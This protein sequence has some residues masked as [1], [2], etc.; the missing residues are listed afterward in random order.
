MI[1]PTKLRSLLSVSLVFSFAASFAVA[2]VGQDDWKLQ[3]LSYNNPGLEVDLGVGLWAWPMPMDYDGDGDIDLLVACPDKPSNGVYFFEN[4]SQDPA[5]QMPVFKP[6]V[7]VGKATS[8]MQVSYVDQ[9]P[10]ILRSGVEFLRDDSTGKFDFDHGKKIYPRSNVHSNGVRGN[11]WRYM[12][13]DGDGD[14]DIVVG[15]GDWTDYGWD[16][17]YDS[18]GRWRN[19]PLHGHVYLI[20][21]DGT[22]DKADYSETPQRLKAAG[23][24]IDVYGWPSPN[25][26][27][28]D[29][30]G[31]LDLLCGEFLDGFT[32]F[33]NVGSRTGPK[34]AAGQKLLN[35]SGDPLVMHLQMITPTALDWDGD[36]DL[37]LIVGDEDGRVAF[38]EN[39]GTLREGQPVFRSPRYFQQ[40][41]DT[42]KFGALATPFAY[43]WDGDGDEDILCGNTA[44]NI[45]LFENLGEAENGM[46]RWSAPE[47]LQVRSSD[48]HGAEDFRVLAGPSGSIQGP[49]EAKWGYTTLSVADWD[50]DGDPDI[51]Y[52]SILARLGLLRNE[53]GVLVESELTMTPSEQPPQ[54]YWWQT[55]ATNALTQWRTTPLATDFDGDGVLDL[56][57]LDQQGFLTLRRGAKQAERIFVDESGQPVQLNPKSC[58]GSGRVKLAVVDWDGDGRLDVLVNSENATWY[59]NGADRDGKVVLKK[60]GRLAERNVAGHTSSPAACD[61]NRDSKPDLLV[62][63]ENGRLYYIEHDD[64]RQFTAEEVAVSPTDD[65]SSARMP[66]LVAEEFIFTR[67]PTPEC[68]ASTICQTSRGLVSAWFAG[69]KEGK[70]DVGIWTSYHDGNGWSNP[71]QVAD[72]VQ[73]DGLRYPCWNPVL[74]QPPGD[75]PTLLFFKVGPNPREWWGEM[76]V[77]YDRGRTFR[78]RRRLP[79]GIDGPVRCKPILLDDG[80][81]LCGSSTEYDG[82][83]IHFERVELD[84]GV[85]TGTWQRIGP[86]NDASKFNAIQ[87]TLLRQDDGTLKALCRTKEGVIVSTQS[88]DGGRSWSPL[89]ATE[90]PNPNSG[91]DVVNLQDGRHL[92]I[93]NHLGSGQT[94]WGR[95]GQL[96]LAISDDG[97]TWQRVGVLEQEKGAEFSYP[98]IIQT[99]DG[100]VHATYTWKRKRVKHVVLNP[101]ALVHE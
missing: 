15:A 1:D 74:Y 47:L 44:G 59:R 63:A 71:K 84:Q 27:D 82:W 95:R 92:L 24:D 79:E 37:D 8:N 28:F 100:K 53:A 99:P 54:W 89:N 52:N 78:D 41:A 10:R 101:A 80:S 29:G 90:L 9:Q 2:V 77:S 88:N 12:D 93:Y 43:D 51:L 3:P 4:P 64:C 33:E 50:A 55:R 21:N 17:A 60:I 36:G 46:P 81:L 83:R 34:Y 67:E 22:A 16:H 13:F 19:G 42:L 26:A 85:P 39:T 65:A 23:G 57:M 91:I 30:D 49:C 94:G 31:D 40:Q 18:M 58:G 14:Q 73:H 98:A 56:V 5:V 70:T 6:A 48:G 45:A 87:P 35:D 97:E 32:Y 76:M 7:R 96:N 11:M 86:I 38:V 20:T 69:T 72:G 61:L 25:F 66:G 68:H 75:A 62:G